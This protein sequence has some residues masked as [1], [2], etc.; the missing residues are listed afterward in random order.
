MYYA[1]LLILLFLHF[2]QHD[3]L[4]Y[5]DRKIINLFLYFFVICFSINSYSR[6]MSLSISPF[7]YKSQPNT[8][9]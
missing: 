6:S 8:P 5:I 7:S 1:Y 9:L 3:Y 4:H 2:G